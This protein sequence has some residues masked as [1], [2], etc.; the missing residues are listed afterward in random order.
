MCGC[1]CELIAAVAHE[2]NRAASPSD[3]PPPARAPQHDAWN[4]W[5]AELIALGRELA[6]AR[7][8]PRGAPAPSAAPLPGSAP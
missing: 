5:W 4:G 1:G 2:K 7:K 3:A 6:P 8:V